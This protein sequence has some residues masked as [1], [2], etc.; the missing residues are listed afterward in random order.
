MGAADYIYLV[1]LGLFPIAWTWGAFIFAYREMGS[2]MFKKTSSRRI[3]RFAFLCGMVITWILLVELFLMLPQIHWYN[4]VF[5][6]PVLLVSAFALLQLFGKLEKT[7]LSAKKETVLFWTMSIAF[8]LL[9]L[10]QFF[11]R[12]AS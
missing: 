2:E 3:A 6:P 7:P 9:I 4:L 10:L 12:F 11:S 5:S 8:L 1:I